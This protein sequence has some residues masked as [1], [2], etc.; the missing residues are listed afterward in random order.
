MRN[1]AQNQDEE[2]SKIFKVQYYEAVCNLGVKYVTKIILNILKN[3]GAWEL[4]LQRYFSASKLMN[5]LNYVSDRIYAFEWMLRFLVNNEHLTTQY[6]KDNCL[7]KTRIK[8]PEIN[9][10]EL[11]SSILDIDRNLLPSCEYMEFISGYYTDFFQGKIG[12]HEILFVKDKMRLWNEYFSNENSGYAVYNQLGA[13]GIKKWVPEIIKDITFFEIGTGTGNASLLAL[14]QLETS[15]LNDRVKNYILSDI[16]PIFL[17]LSKLNISE[18]YRGNIPVL[19]KKID[20]NEP[21][22]KQDISFKDIHVIYG[23]NVLHIAKDLLFS[24]KELYNILNPGGML[25]ISE[26]IREKP[27]DTLVQEIIFNLLD[28]FTS[29][30]LS[31]TYRTTPGFLTLDEWIKVFKCAGFDNIDYVINN[32]LVDCDKVKN[33]P[34]HAMVLRG[35]KK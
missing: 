17:R 22:I 28:S 26:C 9:I 11:R 6:E 20:F 1:L 21:L 10:D 15:G 2:L 32:G 23:V 18:N 19:I 27:S 7:Y 14:N 24:L 34:M 25:V 31:E 12:G 35:I 29:V 30:K 13:L 16:S 4:L 3:S 33:C 8:D 5:K